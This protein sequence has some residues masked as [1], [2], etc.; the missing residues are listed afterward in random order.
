L[1]T[2]CEKDGLIEVLTGAPKQFG[3]QEIQKLHEVHLLCVSLRNSKRNICFFNPEI[4][5]AIDHPKVTPRTNGISLN[6]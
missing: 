3:E 5:D 2:G 1:L 4:L 6:K